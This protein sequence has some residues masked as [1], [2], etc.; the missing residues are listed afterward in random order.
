MPYTKVSDLP[1]YVPADKATQWMA[2]FNNAYA[3]AVAGGMSKDDAE[4]SA[5]KQANGVAGPNA[6]GGSMLRETRMFVIGDLKAE[7]RAGDAESTGAMVVAGY[8]ATYN[9]PTI[10]R[11]WDNFK[12]VIKPGAF[13]RSVENKADVR[14]LRNQDRKS[15]V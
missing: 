12:E 9:R 3:K 15:V 6:K 13:K 10:I 14:F 1:D 8:A 5:F 11:G 4:Q 2:V 7:K